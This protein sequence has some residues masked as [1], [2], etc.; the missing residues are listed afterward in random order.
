MDTQ[1]SDTKSFGKICEATQS[2]YDPFANGHYLQIA[3]KI[4]APF[5]NNSQFSNGTSHLQITKMQ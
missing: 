5:T 4:Q 3:Y 2:R 1:D